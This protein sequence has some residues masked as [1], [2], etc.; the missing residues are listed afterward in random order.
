MLLQPIC[1]SRGFP[2]PIPARGSLLDNS[3]NPPNTSNLYQ[4]QQGSKHTP[5]LLPFCPT[6]LRRERSRNR[7]G[8][9]E[10]SPS[11][12]SCRGLEGVFK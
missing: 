5:I 10:V 12:P 7:G 8:W 1:H 2:T 4:H 11:E 6:V 9:G 3:Q